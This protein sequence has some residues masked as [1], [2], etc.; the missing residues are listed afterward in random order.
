MA[1]SPWRLPLDR[2]VRYA[3]SDALAAVKSH[4]YDLEYAQRRSP[5]EVGTWSNY[6]AELRSLHQLLLSLP[7]LET[8]QWLSDD[9]SHGAPTFTPFVHGITDAKTSIRR[10]HNWLLSLPQADVNDS[11]YELNGSSVL[12]EQQH[13]IHQVDQA[14]TQLQTLPAPGS[15]DWYAR[16][17]PTVEKAVASVTASQQSLERAAA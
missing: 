15:D 5:Q 10:V 11:S 12:R 8:A 7:S 3:V 1:T 4:V 14:L 6:L 17:R 13:Y 9:Q 16:Y 2:A